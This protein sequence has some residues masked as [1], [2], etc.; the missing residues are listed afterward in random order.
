MTLVLIGIPSFATAAGRNGPAEHPGRKA[1]VGVG[2]SRE[3]LVAANHARAKNGPKRAQGRQLITDL[4]DLR[5][6]RNAH[7]DRL[8]KSPRTQ[9]AYG[10][11]DQ[12]LHVVG[13]RGA[14][15]DDASVN[16]FDP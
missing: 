16:P 15:N 5:A 4:S 7:V 1:P 10:L 11:E 14:L 2:L 3:Q 13:R 8:R 9:I 12:L 6:N